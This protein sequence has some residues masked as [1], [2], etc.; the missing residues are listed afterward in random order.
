MSDAESVDDEVEEDVEAD[1]VTVT[2]TGAQVPAD[3]LSVEV[4]SG[5]TAMVD[6]ELGELVKVDSGSTAIVELEVVSVEDELEV[7]SVE[8]ELVVSEDDE[9]VVSL[10]VD[11]LVEVLPSMLVESGRTVRVAEEDSTVIVLAIDSGCHVTVGSH[12]CTNRMT[13]WRF[14]A[15]ALHGIPSMI[16]ISSVS[17]DWSSHPWFFS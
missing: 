9:L 17:S 3:V 13:R 4:L 5:S 16:T 14:P 7:V 8:D 12:D 1:W 6:D 15:D 2:V 10:E 11:E